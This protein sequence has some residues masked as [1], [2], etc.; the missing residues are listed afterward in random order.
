MQL[1]IQM[2]G[3]PRTP[4]PVQDARYAADWHSRTRDAQWREHHFSGGGNARQH[5]VKRQKHQ[6]NPKPDATLRPK[7]KTNPKP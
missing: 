4:N 1:F 2:L 6:P 5:D 3:S 7:P